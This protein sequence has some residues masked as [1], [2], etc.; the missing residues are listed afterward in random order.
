MMRK[1]ILPKGAVCEEKTASAAKPAIGIARRKPFA[2]SPIMR[3]I[4]RSHQN[5]GR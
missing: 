4:M 5:V 3:R 1:V 2:M